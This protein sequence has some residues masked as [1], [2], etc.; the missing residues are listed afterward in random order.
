MA[1]NNTAGGFPKHPHLAVGAPALTRCFTHGKVIEA[2]L[3]KLNE[4]GQIVSSQIS[5]AKNIFDT[6]PS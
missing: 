5:Q 6:F 4:T 1:G 2:G 3:S